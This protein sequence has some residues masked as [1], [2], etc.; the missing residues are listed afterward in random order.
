LRLS[1]AV[2]SSKLRACCAHEIA[3]LTLLELPA[4]APRDKAQQADQLLVG[5]ASCL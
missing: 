2:T 1:N 4:D 3:Y 5:M